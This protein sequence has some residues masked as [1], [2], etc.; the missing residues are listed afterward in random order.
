MAKELNV[1]TEKNSNVYMIREKHTLCKFLGK[2]SHV[3]VTLG[4]FTLLFSSL[5]QDAITWVSF[6]NMQLNCKQL[7]INVAFRPNDRFADRNTINF[8]NQRIPFKTTYLKKIICN[9]DQ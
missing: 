9:F 1:D 4:N 3:M 5:R 6:G 2:S 7:D 8:L